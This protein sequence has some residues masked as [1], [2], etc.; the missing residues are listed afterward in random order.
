MDRYEGK[1]MIKKF[2]NYLQ[3]RHKTKIAQQ[4]EQIM[5]LNKINSSLEVFYT[6]Y[7]E[8]LNLTSNMDKLQLIQVIEK[9]IV[10]AL[11][12]NF[13]SQEEEQRVSDFMDYYKIKKEDLSHDSL[14]SLVKGALLRDLFESRINPRFN[15]INLP[16]KLMKKEVLI[17]AFPSINI[18][19][20][21]TVKEWQRG[22]QGVSFRVMKGVY[23]RMGASK[24]KIVESR[25]RKDL[26]TGTLAVTTHH[27][28]IKVGGS[29]SKRINLE[30]IISVEAD[31]ESVVIFLDGQRSN[32]ICFNTSD[33]WFLAN[34]IQNATN[35]Q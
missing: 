5:N 9:S 16:F 6:D 3:S 4:N 30:K 17:W 25:E 29:F 7:P 32:P 35:W 15:A 28:Y 23:W 20:I 24:G 14:E 19:E 31:S 26:G 10:K 11:E 12:D 34:L 1:I 22:S 21:V 8:L 13:L 33:T 27:L 18:S 2:I